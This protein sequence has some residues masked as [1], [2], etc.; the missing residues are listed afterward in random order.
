MKRIFISLLAITSLISTAFAG[1]IVTNTNQSAAWVRTLVRDAAIDADA[2]YFNPAGVARMKD[3][4]F[5]EV[6]NQS[7][8]QTKTINNEYANL[9]NGEYIGDV[10]AM[11]F[12]S[13]YL[14]Y[15]KGNFA[16]HGGFAIVGGGGSAEYKT[17]LPSFEK[18]I[19]DIPDKL[20]ASGI[21]TTQ[22]SSDIY[23][24]GTSA[25]MGF[26]L[27]ASYKINDFIAVGVG[28]RYIIGKNTYE[29]H[30]RDI[31]IN[32]TFTNA[33]FTGTMVSAPTFFS[34]METYLTGVSGMASG[35]AADLDPYIATAGGYT[36]AQLVA[37]GMMT[38]EDADKIT[39]GYTALGGNPTGLTLSQLQTGFSDF[40]TFYTEKA[41]AMGA[42]AD[43]TGNVEVDA[44]QTGTAF[45]PFI[46][47]DLSMMDGNL[48][49]AIKYEHKTA[50][51]MKNK[52]TIDGSGMFPDGEEVPAD[53]P[54]LLTV[55]VR[56]NIM[57]NFR[58]QIGFHY[59]MDKAAKYGKQRYM[60]N[61]AYVEDGPYRKYIPEEYVT[62]GE[63]DVMM[64]DGSI[65]TYL[66]KNSFELGVSLEYDVAKNI[67]LSG[68]YLYAST[69][70][71][72]AY[73]TDMGYTLV[74]Q[75]FGF[76]G[77]AHVS[78]K[79]DINLGISYTSYS[80]GDNTFD[81]SD[82][83]STTGGT[84]STKELYDKKTTVFAIG[85]GYRF[86][87]E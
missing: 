73:Q 66:D 29:G 31:M 18:D 78:D 20:T 41:S 14:G 34:T 67:S 25:Y 62:N 77:I 40:A 48:G 74:S 42:N 82:P 68:G 55:G 63:K 13:A 70:P 79:F 38:Q 56:Y 45:T 53:M 21:P 86:G 69:S 11:V 65:G 32:P 3:G 84:I 72:L 50:M 60:L 59:Y 81:Y 43:A 64:S 49:V 23:F 87:K 61:P 35:A 12:P 27:G 8:F 9:N 26:Q 58:T 15:K 44:E 2:V 10:K 83:L 33:G 1:G 7:I 37:Y 46:G 6:D 39:N 57:D 16:V 4:F 54:A 24:A 19:S 28:G 71:T 17:G 52:T 76:G 75:T 5:I 47:V 85:F 80:D 51:T 30:I 36:P 22:Y